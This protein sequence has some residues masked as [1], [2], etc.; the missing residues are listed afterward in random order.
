MK[1][2]LKALFDFSS[3]PF[4]I[5]RLPRTIPIL[6]SIRNIDIHI[7]KNE[8]ET[9]KFN[10]EQE[11]ALRIIKFMGPKGFFELNDPYLD[12]IVSKMLNYE[13]LLVVPSDK[14]KGLQFVSKNWWIQ[15]VMKIC[16]KS[17]KQVSNTTETA[18]FISTLVHL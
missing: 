7:Y 4:K 14:G 2:E 12:G 18:H 17:Y 3:R 5:N 11:T 10:H 1:R 8:Q 15:Q 16:Q 6:D 9:F 13:N